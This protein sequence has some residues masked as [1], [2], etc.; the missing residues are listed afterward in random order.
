[1]AT[2]KDGLLILSGG[3][4]GLMLAAILDAMEEEDDGK[5]ISESEMEKPDAMNLLVSKIRYEAE[6]ALASCKNDEER[7]QIYSQVEN[8]VRDMQEKLLQ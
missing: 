3:A 7:E 8:S 1:M 2:W 6:A 5:K 4:L